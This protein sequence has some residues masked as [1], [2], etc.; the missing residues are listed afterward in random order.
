MD[1]DNWDYEEPDECIQLGWERL[2][3]EKWYV[4]AFCFPCGNA[5]GLYKRNE[6]VACRGCILYG[7]PTFQEDDIDII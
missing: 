3:D 5:R 6:V 2:D 1:E 7:H 4:A